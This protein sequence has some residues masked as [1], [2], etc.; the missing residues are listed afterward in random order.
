MEQLNQHPRQAHVAL[1]DIVTLAGNAA[2][3]IDELRATNTMLAA[4]LAKAEGQ[5]QSQQFVAESLRQQ[6]RALELSTA[7]ANDATAWY[8]WFQEKFGNSIFYS[9]LQKSYINDHQV[10]QTESTVPPVRRMAAL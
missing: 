9:D 6:L 5:I 7:A 2:R 4:D 8:S 10:D 1:N 3:T